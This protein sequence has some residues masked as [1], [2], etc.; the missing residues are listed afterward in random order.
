MELLFLLLFI[1][2]GGY[3]SW[4][5]KGWAVIFY[6]F[7][8]AFCIKQLWMLPK[9]IRQLRLLENDDVNS[10]RYRLERNAFI[11]H[12]LITV[13]VFFYIVCWPFFWIF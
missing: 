12:W 2:I 4:Y 1:G 10:H 13:A 9:D 11:I 7:L 6:F 3:A 5:I 8:I